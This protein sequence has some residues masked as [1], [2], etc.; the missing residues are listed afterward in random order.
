MKHFTSNSFWFAKTTTFINFN[1]L[2][3]SL[4]FVA[5]ITAC[6]KEE[7]YQKDYLEN[8]FADNTVVTG[9]S[10]GGDSSGVDGSTQGGVSAGVTS[11]TTDG[12]TG[13]SSTGSATSGSATGGS[14]DGSTAGGSTTGSTVGGSTTGSTTGS[15]AG[16]ATTGSTAGGATTGATAGGAT[17]GATAGGSTTGATTGGVSYQ[18][19]TENFTQNAAQTKKVDIMWVI[20]NSGSMSDEQTALGANFDSFISSF[21]NLNADFKMGITT[22]DTSSNTKKGKMVTGSDVKL[23]SAAAAANPNQFMADFKNLVKVGISGSG[24]EMGLMATEGF[25]EKYAT[26]STPF[27]RPEAYLAVVILSDEEDQ[28]PKAVAAYTEYLKSFKANPGLV[29]IYSIVNT[30]NVNTGGNT[31]GHIRYKNASEQTAGVV[32]NI[33]DD[34]DDVLLEMGQSIVDLLDS[35]A[36]GAAVVDGS[37]HVYVNG[38]ETSSYTYDSASHSIKFDAGHLPPVGAQVTVKY[39]KIM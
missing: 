10:N 20:D 7:F 13:G 18:D 16:G 12:T 30:N 17:T 15:T 3:M 9:G 36:L 33:M 23:T 5:S 37:L 11:G 32:A 19:V 35:F 25:M 26:G 29:K 24:N 38:V 34:F 21:I 27:V 1:R 8:P 14:T 31:I 39:K 22:T 28:S 4:F 6:N 2:A